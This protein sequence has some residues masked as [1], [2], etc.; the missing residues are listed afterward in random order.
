MKIVSI[1][2]SSGC[3]IVVD[4][5]RVS[6][7]HAILR[8]YP[9]G[10][11]EIIDL[12][13]NGTWVNGV[14]LKTNVPFPVKRK[15]VVNFAGASQ[16]NW[17]MVPDTLKY[18]KYAI[19]AIIALAL[20]A[21]AASL[22]SKC[23]SSSDRIIETPST[24]V[25]NSTSS[26]EKPIEND[27]P[28]KPLPAVKEKQTNRDVEETDAPSTTVKKGKTVNELFPVVQKPKPVKENTKDNKA[29]EDKKKVSSNKNNKKSSDK[30]KTNNQQRTGN[31]RTAF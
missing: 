22:L 12:S 4:D 18:V 15:D 27:A 13:Q 28:S 11:M 26:V 20:L 8:I 7:R 30:S 6:R 29:K 25:E 14:R 2:R 3:N 24:N 16:L 17:S 9:L 19:L 10:K 5:N 1:G 31:K 21:F 23:N